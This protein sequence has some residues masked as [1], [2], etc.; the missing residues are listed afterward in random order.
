MPGV[1]QLL[2]YE[3]LLNCISIVLFITFYVRTDN[4]MA[5]KKKKKEKKAQNE[6]QRSTKQYT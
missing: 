2:T 4:T 1:F 3:L 6:K 5:K